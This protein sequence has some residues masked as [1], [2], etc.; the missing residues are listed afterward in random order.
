MLKASQDFFPREAGGPDQP[1]GVGPP[2]EC[3]ILLKTAVTKS[4]GL[5]VPVDRKCLRHIPI[6][7]AIQ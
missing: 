5:Q 2:Y 3:R 4:L 7:P 1:L 6:D